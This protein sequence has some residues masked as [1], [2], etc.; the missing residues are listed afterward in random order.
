[1]T[2]IV[3]I[4]ANGGIGSKVVELGLAKGFHVTAVVRD[5]SKIAIT[6]CELV[7]VQ[8]DILNE[9][10]LDSILSGKDAVVS[11]IG[12]S[13]LKE[14]TLYSKG[15]E[16]II[17][18]M[19]YNHVKR[20]LFVSASGL[21]VNPT[22]SFLL[23]FATRQILQRVLRNMYADLMR[24]EAII[25]RSDVDWTIV[26]PPR[27]THEPVTGTYR[28][29]VNT[30][31]DDPRTISRANVAHYIINKLWDPGAIKATVE[32]ADWKS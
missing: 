12:S 19:Q 11:A 27:L 14:T 17:A 3:V 16:N 21:D 18:S 13:S 1:M 24:M 28:E 23:R 26:R 15:V 22:H 29:A 20:A 25:K 31:L 30:I 10:G 4:G 6:H 2:G 32:I 8:C 9:G 7:V 5:P